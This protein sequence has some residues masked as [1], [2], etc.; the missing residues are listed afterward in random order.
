[1]ITALAIYLDRFYMS[2]NLP[3]MQNNK[4]NIWYP[5]IKDFMLAY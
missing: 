1:M 5:I 3:N 2:V 4:R